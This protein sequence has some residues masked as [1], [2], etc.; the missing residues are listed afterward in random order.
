VPAA[1]GAPTVGLVVEGRLD[2]HG[3][4]QLAYEG[5]VRAEHELGV[6]ARVLRAGSPAGVAQSLGALARHGYDLVVAVGRSAAE[7]VAVAAK[8]FPDTRFAIVDADARALD[9]KPVNVTGLVFEEQQVGY[10]AGYL[11]ALAAKRRGGRV[12]SAVG[13][14]GDPGAARLFAGYRSGARQAVPG[15][16]VLRDDAEDDADRATC[17]RLARA[18]LEQGSAVVL[19]AAGPCGR[20]ALDAARERRAWGIGVDADESSLGPFVLTSTVKGSDVAVFAAIKSVVRGGLA[21]GRNLR[22]GLGGRGVRLGTVSPLVARVDVDAIR[23]VERLLAG[24]AA[25]VPGR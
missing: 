23:R 22:F 15:I 10:L 12:I 24:G 7:P 8:R 14:A 17:E 16:R 6:R 25:T 4:N 3:L 21:G 1:P 9:G 19:G 18:Q 11:A 5:L 20:G 2:D 13:G